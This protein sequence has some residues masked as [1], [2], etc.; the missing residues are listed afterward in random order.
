MYKK[1]ID[2]IKKMASKLGYKLGDNL[3]QIAKAKVMFQTKERPNICPCD[4]DDT[5]MFCCSKKCQDHVETHGE[6]HCGTFRKP[7]KRE[8]YWDEYEKTCRPTEKG[9][10][11]YLKKLNRLEILED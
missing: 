8:Y 7:T 11:E 10:I 3:E 1:E 5:A 2:R 4:P 9:F 6:C